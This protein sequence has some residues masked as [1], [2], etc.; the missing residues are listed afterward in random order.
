M[1]LV[2]NAVA[3]ARRSQRNQA[4]VNDV[5]T[6][7]GA[8]NDYIA[9]RNTLPENWDDV[10]NSITDLN[11]YVVGGT[12]ATAATAKGLTLFT[13]G[14]LAAGNHPYIAGATTTSGTAPDISI[15]FAVAT[16]P[17]TATAPAAPAAT[18][19]W[20]TAAIEQDEHDKI[21]I[22]RNAQCNAANDG[23]AYGG[24]RRMV[25]LYRLEG[26]DGITCRDI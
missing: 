12:G 17:L 25:I 18:S 6:I 26:Q 16:N 19:L 10:D 13:N 20:G 11:Q 23:I 7:A 15:D 1:A 4:R 5:G 22:I 3:G 24:I 14:A 2:L 8:V 9:N 21:S